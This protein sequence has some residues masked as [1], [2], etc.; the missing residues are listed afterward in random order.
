MRV[1]DGKI[2]LG[3]IELQGKQNKR[4]KGSEGAAERGFDW[5]MRKRI[6]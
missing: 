4:R 5:G 3:F 6:K 2:K 1:V